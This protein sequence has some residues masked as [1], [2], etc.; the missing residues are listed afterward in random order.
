MK[1][2]VIQDWL[3][4]FHIIQSKLSN[5]TEVYVDWL[6]SNDSPNYAIDKDQLR[7]KLL[8]M[9]VTDIIFYSC[10][11]HG[12]HIKTSNHEKNIPA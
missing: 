7:E 6:L 12:G 9:G 11:E 3:G 1:T 10:R 4:L 2:Y 5:P 8:T